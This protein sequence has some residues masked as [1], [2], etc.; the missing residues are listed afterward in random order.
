MFSCCCAALSSDSQ[1]GTRS[2][3]VSPITPTLRSG[4]GGRNGPSWTPWLI[5]TEWDSPTPCGNSL[6]SISSTR[7]VHP[8]QD[9]HMGSSETETFVLLS[10]IGERLVP[11]RPVRPQVRHPSGHRWQLQVQKQR[12]I[13]DSVVLLQGK[14]SM[15]GGTS[16]L[17]SS[18]LSILCLGIRRTPPT[19]DPDLSLD[20]LAG[21]A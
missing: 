18:L 17:S 12:P 11:S 8:Q 14:P 10:T 19:F 4:S 20:S 7:R 6:L 13:P 2:S 16:C 1:R 5:T 9:G 3:T 21:T 15:P